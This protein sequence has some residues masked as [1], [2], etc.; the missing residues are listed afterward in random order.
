MNPTTAAHIHLMLCHTPVLTI[1]FGVALLIIG[2]LRGDQG[3]Q[4][5]SLILLVGAAALTI[6]VYLTG[7]PAVGAAKGSPEFVD[8]ILERHKTVSAL[9]MAG[10]VVLGIV[11]LAGL[12]LFRSRNLTRWFGFVLLVTGMI[13]CV[14]LIWTAL[15]PSTIAG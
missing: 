9:A 2:L 10:C 12:L 4:K 5:I 14:V 11:A 1:M 8:S 6:P 7:E 13:E 15:C 3:D